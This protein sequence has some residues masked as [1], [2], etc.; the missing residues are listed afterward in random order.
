MQKL[1][2]CLGPPG[3]FSAIDSPPGYSLSLRY[4]WPAVRPE[5]SASKSPAP[6]PTL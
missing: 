4:L 5:S 3:S 6:S 1:G 2:H